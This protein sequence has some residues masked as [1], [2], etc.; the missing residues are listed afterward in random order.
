MTST[1]P[2]GGAIP[3]TPTDPDLV[4]FIRHVNGLAAL[5]AALG[6]VPCPDDGYVYDTGLS[7]VGWRA[8]TGDTD[9]LDRV[10]A[11]VDALPA[12]TPPFWV[13]HDY[14][15]ATAPGSAR[16]ITTAVVGGIRVTLTEEVPEQ[17]TP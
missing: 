10:R 13:E 1:I 7:G 5:L 15:E 17:V 2:G 12:D 16:R 4:V 6:D 8:V 3:L 11:A 9:S 14:P